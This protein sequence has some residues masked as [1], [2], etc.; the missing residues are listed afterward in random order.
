MK[1]EKTYFQI[2][3]IFLLLST[4]LT[5]NSVY[6][7]DLMSDTLVQPEYTLDDGSLFTETIQTIS[8]SGKIFIISN[9]N[10]LLTKGD[11]LTMV[12]PETKSDTITA[13]PVARA[14]VAKTHS[15]KAG[16]KVLKVYSLARWKLL[17]SP[18]DIQIKRG[19]DTALFV[20]KPETT[21][22]A[23]EG[24]IDNEEDLFSEAAMLEKELDSG[25]EEPRLIKPD[26]LVTA[27]WARYQVENSV[28]GDTVIG[29]QWNFTWGYQ[30]ANNFWLEGLYGRT[31]LD[32]FPDN[33]LQ[34]QV[35][36]FTLRLKY[37]F[38]APLYSYFLPYVGIRSY[39]VSS[40]NAGAL[41]TNASEDQ[42]KQ[43]QVEKQLIKDMSTT[44]IAV[45]VT[46]LRRLV[47]GWF[48]KVDLG[49][50]ILGVGFG[51]EF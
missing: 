12:L 27:A 47:P 17:R 40:P 26:N 45:G 22:I 25:E 38:K 20:R 4:L 28:S 5:I 49:T 41:P 37:T 11:F 29:N 36:N 46:V 7:Q 10:Q 24:T 18:L 16:I 9:N 42:Q 23:E 33:S 39:S 50:D 30:F 32:N 15:G 35:N 34:T 8:R 21:E 1:K 14:V 43:A 2:L 48:L 19:D 3:S 51:I 31:L 44:S 6:S 13:G